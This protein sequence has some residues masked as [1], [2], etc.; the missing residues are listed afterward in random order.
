MLTGAHRASAHRSRL[1]CGAGAGWRWRGAL[2]VAAAGIVLAGW[3]LE[4]AQAADDVPLRL[5][6]AQTGGAE[7]PRIAVLATV[8]GEPATQMPLQIRIAPT[9]S[10]PRNSFLRLR[11]LPPTASLSEGHSIAPGAWA[12]PLNGLPRLRL[13][14]PASIAGKSDLVISLVDEDGKLLA[15]ARVSLVIQ[16][17]AP[18]SAPPAPAAVEEKERVAPPP[19]ALAP[20]LTPADRE[21][22][23]KLVARGERDLEQG[24]IAQARQFFLRAAQT[25]LAQGALMLAATYDPRELARMRAVSVQPNIAEARKWYTRAVELGAPDAAHK[26]ATLGGN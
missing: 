20:A 5:Q 17:Q 1:T 18:A 3:S 8:V 21:N 22:A 15:E 2:A 24:N 16:Q 9:E 26:L 23:E 13:N 7:I 19:R 4:G 11:G 6:L 25:G 10:I 14:L 12:I